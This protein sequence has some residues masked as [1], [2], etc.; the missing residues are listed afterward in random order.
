[1]IGKK[2]ERN[3]GQDRRNEIGT[4]GDADHIIGKS[5]NLFS[6]GGGDGNHFAFASFDLLDAVDVL[7]VDRIIRSDHDRRYVRSDQRNDAV[8]EF[9]TG[10]TFSELVT[11]LL[12][13]QSSFQGDRI[14]V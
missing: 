13:L 14:I 11:D 6:P 12:Q 3:R 4:F 5:R 8:L 7:L 10:M 1:M 2:L 9:G